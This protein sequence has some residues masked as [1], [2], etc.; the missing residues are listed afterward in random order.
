MDP[1]NP[2]LRIASQAV[3][4]LLGLADLLALS[5][6]TEVCRVAKAVRLMALQIDEAHGRLADALPLDPPPTPN[7]R[8]PASNTPPD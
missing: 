5:P 8:D 2:D 6:H 4:G 1:L 7:D 3:D